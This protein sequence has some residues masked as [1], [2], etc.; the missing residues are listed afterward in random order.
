MESTPKVLKVQVLIHTGSTDKVTVT[1]DVIEPIWPHKNHL[2]M[3][4]DTSPGFGVPY[5]TDVFGIDP[6]IIDLKHAD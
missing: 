2:V 5:A 3:S 6:E 4:F 1:L